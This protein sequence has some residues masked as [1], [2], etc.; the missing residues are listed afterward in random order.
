MGARQAGARRALIRLGALLALLLALRPPAARAQWAVEGFLGSAASAHSTLTIEQAGQPTL[1]F[2]AHYATKPTEPWIYYAFRISHWW[3]R[4][5]GMAGV[6]HHK[7]YLE[8]NPPEVQAFKVTNGYNLV[9]VGPGY[10][11]GHWTLFGTVG[12]VL[13]NPA[14]TVRGLSDTNNGGVF[15]TDNYLNGFNVQLGVNRRFYL[16]SWGF[17]DDRP[18]ALRRLG[19][20]GGRER[21]RRHPE[22]RRPPAGGPGCGVQARSPGARP[23]S[24][25]RP[26]APARPAG[27]H[28]GL[29]N[30]GTSALVGVHPSPQPPPV[31][32]TH[33]GISVPCPNRPRRRPT[34]PPP[35]PPAASPPIPTP[36]WPPPA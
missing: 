15:A 13:S 34:S 35:T 20:H 31:R 33:E 1:S 14:S 24:G 17:V 25:P 28:F 23:G 19:R 27:Y 32:S 12:P 6:V 30:P 4:W 26:L 10:L 16:F 5:G 8:N 21:Q 36:R 11:A 29:P 18:P 22:L 3:G 7:I 2:T 9:G